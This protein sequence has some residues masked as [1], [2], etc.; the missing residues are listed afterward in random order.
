MDASIFP[1]FSEKVVTG[2]LNSQVKGKF[3]VELSY[4]SAILMGAL[5]VLFPHSW[6]N[7]AELW[8][9]SSERNCGALS[10]NDWAGSAQCPFLPFLPGSKNPPETFGKRLWNTGR[11][12]RRRG[13]GMWAVFL[14]KVC[15]QGVWHNFLVQFGV[16]PA[17]VG[18]QCLKHSGWKP[19]GKAS[20]GEIPSQ[21]PAYF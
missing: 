6:N 19:I 10:R 13:Q 18:T 2:M 8:L 17:L 1:C 12:T 11:L 3:G 4:I 16:E 14:L 7:L 15:F 5:Q 20:P 9:G 21:V